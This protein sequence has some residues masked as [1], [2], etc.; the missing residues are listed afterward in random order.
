MHE[1]ACEAAVDLGLDA[2]GSALRRAVAVGAMRS[3]SA[4]LLPG[5]PARDS[6]FL[7]G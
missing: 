6:R 1:A 7:E 4:K 3:I 2:L 5:T